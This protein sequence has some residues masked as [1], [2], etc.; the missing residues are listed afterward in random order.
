LVLDIIQTVLNIIFC[1]GL[2][3]SAIS[4][5]KTRE[6]RPAAVTF[7][8]L[9]I[10]LITMLLQRQW[11]LAA[12]FVIAILGTGFKSGLYSLVMI[13]AGLWLIIATD[14]VVAPVI[15]GL[16][17]VDFFYKMKWFGGA[18]SQV[19]FALIALCQTWHILAYLVAAT[20]AAWLI[21]SLRKRRFGDFIKRTGQVIQRMGKP[22]EEDEDA[23]RSPWLVPA[24][25]AGLAHILIYPGMLP[26]LN[27]LIWGG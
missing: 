22:V 24:A 9:G 21:L 5:L 25:V 15:V 6:V 18:D 7:G 14:S 19:A 13:G 27:G 16:I 10:S 11:L 4:D 8:L 17:V 20:V 3:W 1:A 2:V 23:I 26:I 12:Y